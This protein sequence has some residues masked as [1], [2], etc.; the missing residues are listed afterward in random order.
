MMLTGDPVR[1]FLEH[2]R[3]AAEWLASRPVCVFCG[4]PIQDDFYYDFGD[5]S[6][7]EDCKDNYVSECMHHINW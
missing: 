1:D 4:E 5:G 2:D 3:E 6:L 7:C